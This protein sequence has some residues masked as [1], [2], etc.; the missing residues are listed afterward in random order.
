MSEPL[1]PDVVVTELPDGVR[2]RLPGRPWGTPAWMGLGA[3][4]G[5]LLGVAFLSFWLWGVGSSLLLP[6]GP[7]AG[8]GMLY[9]FLAL[10]GMMLLMCL[11]LAVRG[12]SRLVGHNEIELRG[13]TLRGFEC[14]GPVRWDRH[15]PAAG[16]VRFDVR[17]ALPDERPGRV[18]EQPGAAAEYNALVATGGGIELP[19]ARGYPRAWLTPLAA[20]LARRCR[21]PDER[22]IAVAEE[23]LPN[24]AGFVDLPDQ[25]EESRV[26]VDR[27]ADELILTLPREAFGRQHAT[28]TVLGDRLRVERGRAGDGEWA[29]RQLADVRVARLIDSEGP[30]TF[31]VHIDP[32]P[33]EGKRVRLTLRG[34]AEARWLATT[35]RRALGMTDDDGDEPLPFLERPERPADCRIIEEPLARGVQFVIPPAGFGHPDVRRYLLLALAFLGAAAGVSA[36]LQ[37]VLGPDGPD[38]DVRDSLR[39]LWLFPGLLALGLVGAVEEVVRRARRHATLGVVGETLLVRQSNLYGTREREWP[40]SRVAD[41]R[42]GHTLEGRSLLGPRTRRAVLDRSDPIWELHIH[43]TGGEVV[44]LFDGYGDADLQWLATALRRALAVPASPVA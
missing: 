6:G 16:L 43:L 3:L 44:R 13:G 29:R 36:F 32:H 21:L 5:G 7:Q 12:L 35:L 27:T 33:G 4:V 28:L 14:W 2:Y 41:V 38:A 34:E 30:D 9:V 10:G 40:R 18:Y 22:A 20:D 39:F 26:F 23:P 17:D 1:P 25:P 15:L 37:F 19:L 8:D 31:Q 24:P 42:V 11:R